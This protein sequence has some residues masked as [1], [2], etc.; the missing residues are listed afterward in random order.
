MLHVPPV[1][2]VTNPTAL[3]VA[4]AALL[5]LHAP[6]PPLNTTVLAVYV[7]VPAI[8]KGLVPVTDAIL[9]TGLTVTA[10]L[11]AELVPQLF[12]AVTV[13]FPFCPAVPVVTVMEVVPA[14]AVIDQPAGTVHV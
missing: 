10:K 2:P 13:M 9:A 6:V 11:L 5:L 14:P 8:H 7:V 1:T 4:I 12:P 3:T